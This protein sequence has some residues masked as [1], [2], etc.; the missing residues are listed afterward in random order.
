MT[1]ASIDSRPDRSR[2]PSSRSTSC[3]ASLGSSSLS[4]FSRRSLIS[5]DSSSSP[6]S[7]WIAFI[8]SRRYISRWRSPELLLDLRLDL[9][10]RL[11]HADLLLDL[12]QD[13]AQPLLDAEGLE[14][15]LLLGGWQLDVAGDQVG[16]P[17][18]V[19]DRVEDL[20]Y[21]LLGQSAPFAELGGPLA[22]LLVERDEGRVVLVDRLHLLD[23]HHDGAEEALGGVELERGGALLTLEQQ[24]NAAKAALDLADAGD[25]AHRVQDV[26]RRLVRVVALS[27][28]EDQPLALEGRLDRA[29][30]PRPPGGDRHR[31]PREDDRAPE[32]ENWKSLASCHCLLFGSGNVQLATRGG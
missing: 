20:V 1:C 19:G 10:L 29:E 16:E 25:D 22:E 28:G 8:C 3:R 18:G 14:E 11:E 17:A 24:L 27:H 21:D 15:A 31:Q 6:S 4:S 32:G 26:R 12:D 13:A 30:R 7:F 9:L 23:R 5:F 2:R